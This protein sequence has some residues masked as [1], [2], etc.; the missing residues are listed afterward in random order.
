MLGEYSDIYLK[1]DVLL[2][3][4]V[5]EGFRATSIQ[6]YGL[7]PAHYHTTPGFSWDAMLKYTKVEIDLLTDIDMLMFVERGIRGGISQCSTR[8]AKANNEYTLC[9]C[10]DKL[11]LEN[12]SYLLYLDVNN[13]YG[14]AMMKSLPLRNFRWSPSRN[15]NDMQSDVEKLGMGFILEVDL[16]YPQALHDLHKDYPLCA[17]KRCPPGSKHPKLLLTL[18]DKSNY[19]IHHAMLK[20]VL[21]HGLKLKKIHRVLQFDERPWLKP[22]ID[23]NTALRTRATNEF[24]KNLYKLMSNA[25]YGKCM[26]NVR[27]RVTI[28]LKSQWDGRYGAANLIANP[29]VKKVTVFDD[30]LV[31]IEMHT[32]EVK[33]F[34]PIVVGMAVLELSKVVMYDF[35]YS[36]MLSQ[37]STENCK[38]VYT[39]TDS[40]I[41]H[42]QTNSG[43]NIYKDIIKRNNCDW[44]D[45]SD[46]PMDNQFQIIPQN[47]KIPGIMKDECNGRIMTEFVGLRSKMYS[48][49]IAGVDAIRKAKGVK[50]YVVKNKLKFTDYLSCLENNTTKVGNQKSLRSVMHQMHTIEQ[51][52]I[53]LSPYDDKRY[54]MPNNIDTLPWG[55]YSIT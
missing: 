6:N 27:N 18:Y 23:L 53:F 16:E 45:T 50:R 5:F 36:K 48:I 52:K 32:T 35:H 26:E 14:Y 38:I 40:F 54:I 4:D 15:F 7:D 55:H 1:T 37:S 28:K 42:I 20:W 51:K 49:K 13:L 9:G 3:S 33:L 47:K 31:A 41:Y 17:E 43:G 10:E 22:Y 21:M 44:F 12:K 11:D 39:D 19:V 2:L 34:K 24:E 8:Y 46:Y 29:N 30:S 25:V